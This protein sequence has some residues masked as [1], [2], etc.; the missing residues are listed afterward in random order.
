MT[1]NERLEIYNKAVEKST[2]VLG[3]VLLPLDEL[4]K[5]LDEV[6]KDNDE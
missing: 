2:W 4:A 5:I 3:C 6:G 1:D